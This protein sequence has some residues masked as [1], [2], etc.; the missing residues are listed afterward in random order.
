MLHIIGL[1]V[2]IIGILLLSV[3]GILLLL[4]LLILLVP[5]R[6]QVWVS[7]H[8]KVQAKIRLTWLL[9]LFSLHAEYEEG[10]KTGLQFFRISVHPAKIA[11][12]GNDTEKV[13]IK[14]K[15]EQTEQRKQ[16]EQNED[17]KS[18]YTSSDQGNVQ[19]KPLWKEPEAADIKKDIYIKEEK[20][21]DQPKEQLV[22]RDV[23]QESH[24]RKKVALKTRW[25]RI[26]TWFFKQKE[27]WRGK[28]RQFLQSWEEKKRVVLKA[29]HFLTSKEN[30][31]TGFLLAR[32]GKRIFLH[33]IP[34]KA[35]GNVTFGFEDP[36]RTG[37]V[38]AIIAMLYP[39]YR[40]QLEVTPIFDKNI[41]EGEGNFKGRIRL[42]TL[43]VF[44]LRLVCD[45]NLRKIG[46]Q[47]LA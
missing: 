19:E 16:N 20:Q 14:V 3:L 30:Q 43:L 35:Q 37:E 21:E 46:K 41:L 13:E 47:M 33:V 26:K 39:I 27:Y 45:K 44:V 36:A 25:E 23:L 38:L 12:A 40:D 32:Q 1:I 4:C 6:Y 11:Q 28:L 22:H 17:R 18:V 10:W 24:K 34:K 29:Y 8:E 31:A 7:Y 9:H 5:L 2:K 15:T 42:G